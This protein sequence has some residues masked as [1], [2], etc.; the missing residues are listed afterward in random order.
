MKKEFILRTEAILASE[1]TTMALGSDNDVTIPLCIL[2]SLYNYKGI[3]EKAVIANKVIDY[4]QELNIEKVSSDKGIKQANGSILRII[5]N[6]GIDEKIHQMNNLSLSDKRVFQVCLDRI[7]KNKYKNIKVI[8]ISQNPSIRIKAKKLGIESE[9]FKDEIFPTLKDQYT[10]RTEVFVLQSTLDKF[11]KN[12]EIGIEEIPE[13]EKISWYENM[14]VVMKSETGTSMLGRYSNGKIKA[15]IYT[16]KEYLKTK[17]AEQEMLVECIS[18]PA[19]AAPL[20]IIKGAAGTGK[21]FCTLAIALEKI[22]KYGREECYDQILIAAPTVNI[23]DEIGYLPGDID[24]KVGPYL[25]G[26][27]DNLWN[28]FRPK[29]VFARNDEIN[30]KIDELFER[31]FIEI[32]VIGFLRGR[33]IQ[34]KIFII[35]EAQNIDPGIIK[36][37]VTRVGERTKIVFMG[38]PS[39]VN[40]VGLSTRRNGLVYISE[41]MKG[42][43]NCWQVTLND[44][45]SIR[46]K[47]AQVALEKL[48]DS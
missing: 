12:K 44:K 47:L 2:E 20:V 38:D 33:S 39:Q 19:E 9:P 31:K 1:K 5:D 32:E 46:S 14:F 43:P 11:Q 8:L 4:I 45:K 42:D 41:K 27:K 24:N 15:F 40:R 34:D 13:N 26:I 23:D 28:L 36:D 10:G 18:A 48:Q 22:K 37:I 6:H 30:D 16:Q 3:P 29:D 25:K 7:E 35:D 21:T 17:N